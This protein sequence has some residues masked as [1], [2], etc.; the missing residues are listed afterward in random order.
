MSGEAESHPEGAQAEEVSR[1]HPP[2]TPAPLPPAR[3]APLARSLGAPGARDGVLRRGAPG[4]PL[5]PVI[6]ATAR[7]FAIV[8][9]LVVVK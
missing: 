3:A 6:E 9:Q 8:I 4:V 1:R 5:S 7:E 2:R